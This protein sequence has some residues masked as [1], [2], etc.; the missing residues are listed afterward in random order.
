MVK[1]GSKKRRTKAKVLADKAE[2]ERKEKEVRQKLAA[3]E[4]LQ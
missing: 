4:Q 1:E 3:F 2:A